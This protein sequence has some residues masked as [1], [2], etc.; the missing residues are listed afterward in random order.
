MNKIKIDFKN[1]YNVNKD[2]FNGLNEDEFV[3]KI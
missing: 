2:E 1:Y 3:N